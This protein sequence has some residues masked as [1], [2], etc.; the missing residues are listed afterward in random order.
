MSGRVE[1]PCTE[2]SCFED[3]TP[4]FACCKPVASLKPVCH[5]ITSVNV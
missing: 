5:Y 1:K 4:T 3:A 2:Q